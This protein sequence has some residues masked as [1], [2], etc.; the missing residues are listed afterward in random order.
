MKLSKVCSRSLLLIPCW[1]LVLYGCGGG[2][3]GGGSNNPA[4]TVQITRANAGDVA[5]AA[6]E[7]NGGLG[8]VAEL[9]T[10]LPLEAEGGADAVQ[11]NGLAGIALL[12]L[13]SSGLAGSPV[14]PAVDDDGNCGVTGTAAITFTDPN[15]NDE[16]DVG[17]SGSVTFNEC[18]DVING[19]TINGTMTL[20]VDSASETAAAFTLGFTNLTIIGGMDNENLS[21]SGSLSFGISNVNNTLVLTLSGR[22]LAIVEDG[23]PLNLAG[24]FDF[25]VTISGTD[26]SVE[27]A[28][29]LNVPSLGGVISVSTTAPLVG[30]P[31]QSGVISVQGV[32][33]TLTLTLTSGSAV[34]VAVDED[35]DGTPEC[36]QVLTV[37]TLDQ[38]DPAVACT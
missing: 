12:T 6:Y 15:G 28:M 11:V 32:G 14:A 36:S 33:S 38:F 9:P 27:F 25:T 31:P 24:N 23:V 3:G 34:T 35:N 29:T 13:R 22:D 19:P 21:A 2:D 4:P 7:T 30:N 10:R 1:A 16:I 5:A 8:E 37:D 18:V 26:S 20:R 17:E